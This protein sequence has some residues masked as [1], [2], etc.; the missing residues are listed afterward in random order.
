M[1]ILLLP[2]LLSLLNVALVAGMLVVGPQ[3]PTHQLIYD[4]QV[5]GYLDGFVLV[6]VLTDILL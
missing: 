3:I 4:T 5:D 1:K 2:G 6:P